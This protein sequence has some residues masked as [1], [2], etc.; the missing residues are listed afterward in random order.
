MRI[1]K[2]ILWALG[3]LI[4]FCLTVYVVLDSVS[5]D[6]YSTIHAV[7]ERG[8]VPFST[9]TLKE[10]T[11]VRLKS[12]YDTNEFLIRFDVNLDNV[13]SFIDGAKIE[14]N[15][16]GRVECQDIKFPECLLF[17]NNPEYVLSFKLLEPVVPGELFEFNFL[18][19]PKSGEVIG[20]DQFPFRES[21]V[22][23]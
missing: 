13:E 20:G 8:W 10:A 4:V 16:H 17:N 18:L 21:L 7:Q 6:E 2:I 3:L 15:E 23:H 22:F 11:N 12:D 14:S 5:Y 1:R 19:D 9:E